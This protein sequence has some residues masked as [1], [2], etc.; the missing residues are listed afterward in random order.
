MGTLA[1]FPVPLNMLYVDNTQACFQV[2]ELWY[3]PPKRIV[4]YWGYYPSRGMVT[5]P[6]I[7]VNMVV[8]L[9][10]Y[11]DQPKEATRT[12]I[13]GNNDQKDELRNARNKH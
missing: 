9:A 7:K 5:R 2:E 6:S 12:S 13:Q 3:G 4:K 1:K 10:T 8:T 11:L